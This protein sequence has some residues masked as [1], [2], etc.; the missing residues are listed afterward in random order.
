MR[1]RH[2]Q[3]HCKN[4]STNEITYK[5]VKSNN[6]DGCY[7]DRAAALHRTTTIHL[8]A[9]I[10]PMRYQNSSFLL[11]FCRLHNWP[12]LYCSLIYVLSNKAFSFFLLS[13]SSS[14]SSRQIRTATH[15]HG[16]NI[17]AWEKNEKILHTKWKRK[18]SE[19]TLNNW[20]VTLKKI[21]NFNWKCS[22]WFR[23]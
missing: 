11:K 4:N 7:N 18:K 20:I 15:L 2:K 12:I 14:F 16:S 19:Q 10:V 8:R 5:M 22:T 13:S 17:F 9:Y 23:F 6:N 3:S 1:T 21:T